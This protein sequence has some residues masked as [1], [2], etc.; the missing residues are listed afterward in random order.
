[1]RVLA[2]DISKSCTGWAIDETAGRPRAGSWRGSNEALPGR[3]GALFS[4][5]LCAM[6]DLHKPDLIAVE[7]AAQGGRNK[8]FVMSVET[9]KM[10]IGL[11]FLSETIAASY[12]LQYREYSVQTVRKTFVG[13]GRPS[14]G[15][16]A[17]QDH[18][19][20]LGW[21]TE[22]TDESDAC[23]VW[24]HA[25]SVNDKSFR[26]ETGTAL[27]GGEP[28]THPEIAHERT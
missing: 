28:T 19:R 16:K 13:H 24:Y 9:S 18:C 26:P 4:E 7:A 6:I 2:L 11:A 10:L 21:S 20:T 25:K 1:M 22:N 3:A 15:K 8:D 27:F 23:A 14:N 17:V 12:R 5:W